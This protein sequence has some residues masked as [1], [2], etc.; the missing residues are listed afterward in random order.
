MSPAQ[1][2]DV[3]PL[4]RL[5][6]VEPGSAAAW[7]AAVRAAD[8][9]GVVDI[10][11]AA[12][13]VLV[14]FA[15]RAAVAALTS[16]LADLDASAEQ[17]AGRLASSHAVVEIPVRY[18]GEDLDDV[19]R[20]TGLDRD[21]VIALHTGSPFRVD[22]CG[23]APGFAYLRGLDE[24][25]VAAASID[26][27]DPG[28]GRIGRDRRRAFGCLPRRVARRMASARND[29]DSGVGRRSPAARAARAGHRGQVRR[30]VTSRAIEVVDVGW[31]TTI[32]DRGR[33][34]LAHLG[35]PT[36]GAVDPALAALV[37]RLVGNDERAAVIETAGGLVVRATAPVLVGDDRRAGAARPGGGGAI[38]D[39]G[40]RRTHV[41]VPR[42]ARGIHGRAGARVAGARHVVGS[43]AGADRSGDV[44]A[45][46]RRPGDPGRRRR[47]AAPAEARSLPGVARPAG[48]LVR[49]RGIGA[50][51]G[52]RVDRRDREPGRAAPRGYRR[53][54]A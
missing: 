48:Q 52:E 42:R 10:V 27:A 32:Q 29:V 38:D 9:P 22:F 16:R 4:A 14:S 5:I 40:R 53:S 51:D 43:R 45:G 46:R 49:R 35:V 41:V 39:P 30:H 25:S 6:E 17:W 34:G 50:A 2:L 11:P 13:T 33:P 36:A 21:E 18:D 37:N 54:G 1:V 12:R 31:S 23:F 7:A 20:A 15:D 3:G 19:A 26:T 24:A 47:R 8:L 44:A 28:A